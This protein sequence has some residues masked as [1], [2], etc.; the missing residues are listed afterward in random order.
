MTT[1]DSFTMTPPPAPAA[2]RRLRRSR[3]DRIGAGV[4][5]GLG[6]YFGVD[7]VLFRVL[8]ATAAF[9]GGAGVL[10]YLLAWAAIPEEGTERAAIDGWIAALRRRRVPFWLVIT[11]AALLLWLVAFSWWAPGPFVPVIV[12]VLI[13]VAIVSHRAR[14]NRWQQSDATQ[15]I[16][17]RKD[18]P[19]PGMPTATLPTGEPTDPNAAP[20]ATP[21]AWVGETRS[22]IREARETRREK[23]RRA[24]P[25]RIA[26]LVGFVITMVV[27]GLIDAAHGIA[28][29]TYFWYA[30]AILGAGFLTG[31][32]LRRT[33]WSVFW[34]LILV[35]IGTFA[36]AGTKVSLR[37]GIGQKQWQP[38]TTV[39]SSYQLAF[40]QAVLDLRDLPAQ[41]TAT[42]T[43][44]DVGAG[45]VKIVIPTGMNVI[46][47]A[48]VHLGVVEVDGRRYDAGFR[49]H[50]INV[51]RTVNAPTGATGEPIT[52][53]V[54]LADGDVNLLHRS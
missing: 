39:A 11:A 7:P 20:A 22:W 12:V 10:A 24:T 3:S 4:S 26:T 1:T 13:G 21:P 19:Q 17:L 16:S 50:G 34:L 52:I 27:L 48:N 41:T 29:S 49:S 40:G 42:S 5:G 28:L 38:T 2:P 18:G 53:D 8:F 31:V 46:V 32:V 33:T 36:F 9:F 30:L 54:H 37:D 35:A 23:L 25:V 15:P 6:N 43:R 44:I 14:P 45:Q 47:H 51:S